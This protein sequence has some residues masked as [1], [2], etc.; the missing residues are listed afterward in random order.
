MRQEAEERAT[1]SA[2]KESDSITIGQWTSAALTP[3][4][5]EAYAHDYA[6]MG[7]QTSAAR[8]Q[9]TRRLARR[10]KAAWRAWREAA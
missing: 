2:S 4:E 5:A 7:A 8:R 6:N 3:E 1:E 9:R 10:A